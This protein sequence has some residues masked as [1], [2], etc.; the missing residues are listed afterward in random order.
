MMLRSLIAALLALVALSAAP[1]AARA[2]GSVHFGVGIGI[3]CCGP[4]Y[5]YP[6]PA[7]Y[8][9]PPYYYYPPPAVTYAPPPAYGAPPAYAAPPA[10]APSASIDSSPP[11][12]AVTLREGR[13]SAG[14]YC[15]EYQ[16]ASQVNG[17]QVTTLGTAC[18]KPDGRW[19]IVN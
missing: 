3:P 15:R 13:D 9:P 4:A 7:Y 12:D 5:Y 6:P 19:Q 10:A 11:A 17:Q 2:G 1:G 18:L 14:N 16:T 8:Y